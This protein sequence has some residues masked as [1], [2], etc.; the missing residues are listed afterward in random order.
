MSSITSAS[1]PARTILKLTKGQDLPNGIARGLTVGTAG[2][3]NLMDADGN[4]C[5]NFPLQQGYNP[6]C[7]SALAAGGTADDIWAL[8]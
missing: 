4:A 1:A 2:T 6:I 7:I 5:D 8:Y 3:A